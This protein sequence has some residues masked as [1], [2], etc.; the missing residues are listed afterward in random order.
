[1]RSVGRGTRIVLGQP[2]LEIIGTSDVP[3]I[4]NGFGLEKVDVHAVP[5]DNRPGWGNGIALLRPAG[6]EGHPT[7]EVQSLTGLPFEARRRRTAAERSRVERARLGAEDLK[8]WRKNADAHGRPSS[9]TSSRY[10]RS[11][12]RLG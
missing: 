8:V 2:L 11:V 1:M 10:A 4:G 3:L 5:T 9:A 7:S 6:Y 12:T